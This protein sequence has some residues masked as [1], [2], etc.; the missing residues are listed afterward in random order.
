MP[1]SGSKTQAGPAQQSSVAAA[2]DRASLSQSFDRSSSA[3]ERESIVRQL[4]PAPEQSPKP[5]SLPTTPAASGTRNLANTPLAKTPQQQH[6]SP[7][8]M[9]SPQAISNSPP[10]TPPVPQSNTALSL[11]MDQRSR[12]PAQNSQVK[13]PP[14]PLEESSPNGLRTSVDAA[15]NN[16]DRAL[17][18]MHKQEVDRLKARI[19]AM[20][21]ERAKLDGE[22]RKERSARRLQDDKI[23][24]LEQLARSSTMPSKSSPGPGSNAAEKRKMDLLE[25]QVTQLKQDRQRE[26]MR[27]VE[28]ES[29]LKTVERRAHDFQNQ[30]DQLHQ[31]GK[32]GGIDPNR[33]AHLEQ[34]LQQSEERRKEEEKRRAIAEGKHRHLEN[35]LKQQSPFKY[36]NMLKGKK[37]P[38]AHMP[39]I[40]EG[41][42]MLPGA[43]EG[44][45]P[46][47][48]D[49]AVRSPSL[50][51]IDGPLPDALTGQGN[52]MPSLQAQQHQLLQHQQQHGMGIPGVDIYASQ[53]AANPATANLYSSQQR[54]Q[55][56]QMQGPGGPPPQAG[57]PGA[58]Q[59]YPQ[60]QMPQYQSQMV[61]PRSQQQ[62]PAP[63]GTAG[64]MSPPNQA[65]QQRGQQQL[66]QP[67]YGHQHG[68]QQQMTP[69]QMQY[70][71]KMMQQQQQQ[72][73]TYGV[74]QRGG[75]GGAPSV[76]GGYGGGA[77]GPQSYPRR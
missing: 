40:S 22:L 9:S 38:P 3:T 26:E 51:A 27:R 37:G 60:A 75:Q 48:L 39:D 56:M 12:N 54:M 71:Q 5:E 77:P 45:M 10:P 52:Y 70:H 19:D 25:K 33:I 16:V 28:A 34:L 36:A 2:N 24:D 59:Q 47:L 49:N 63:P 74:Q 73:G 43:M 23:R 55:Q 17:L 66:Q 31:Q 32:T 72:Q 11:S 76:Y 61:D 46:S 69:Q 50:G 1:G 35:Q 64:M 13:A 57:T 62:P 68:G 58:Q 41:R 8:K 67:P 44:N 30:L 20:D 21:S 15:I 4:K 65:Q 42:E 14:L 18:D 7:A 53:G 29:A 6:V